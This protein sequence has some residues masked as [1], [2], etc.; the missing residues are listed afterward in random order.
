MA[1]DSG[2]DTDASSW[3]RH[4]RR[5]ELRRQHMITAALRHALE[6]LTEH[7]P[8]PTETAAMTLCRRYAPT[9]GVML[10]TAS[11]FNALLVVCITG[12]AYYTFYMFT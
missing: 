4:H 10:M 9:V 12:H 6:Q 3:R 1:I 8:M 7:A 2:Y 5:T 11:V